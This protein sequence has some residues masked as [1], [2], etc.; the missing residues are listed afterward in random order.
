MKFYNEFGDFSKFK[1]KMEKV[2]GDLEKLALDDP[3]FYAYRI[4]SGGFGDYVGAARLFEQI[5]DRIIREQG[6]YDCDNAIH[7]ILYATYLEEEYTSWVKKNNLNE[8]LMKR[9]WHEFLTP[10]NGNIVR[11]A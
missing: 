1:E 10:H 6:T 5:K 11:K 8:D 2:H 9:G 3:D 7:Q 4:L